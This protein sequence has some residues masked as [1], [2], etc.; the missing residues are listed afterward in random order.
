[1]RRAD[2]AARHALAQLAQR[3]ARRAEAS[4]A[5]RDLGG[6]E[7]AERIGATSTLGEEPHEQDVRL[8]GG[9]VDLEQAAQERDGAAAS[10][11]P[12]AARASG[13]AALGEARPQ[14]RARRREPV[15][16]RSSGQRSPR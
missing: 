15:G 13:S 3:H 10:P 4:R 7:L 6:V 16:V 12:A 2:L 1:M 14:R 8:L 5:E 9:R 11:Q